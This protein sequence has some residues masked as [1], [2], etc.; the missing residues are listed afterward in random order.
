MTFDIAVTAA[1][2]NESQKSAGGAIGIQVVRADIGGKS[3]NKIENSS[4]SRVSFSL[5]FIPPS[6]T[7]TP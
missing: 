1:E 4:I 5:P 6:T 2:A 3:S 7:I